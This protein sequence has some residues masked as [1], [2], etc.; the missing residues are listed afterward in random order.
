MWIARRSGTKPIDPGMLDNLVGGGVA[1]GTSVAATVV[2]EAWEEAGIPAALSAHARAAGSVG[3]LRMQPDGLHRETIHVHDLELPSAFAPVNQDGEV[4][5][6]RLV[7]VDTLVT[8]LG[9]AEGPDVMTA[10]AS[11]V[12]VDW[13]L[14]RGFVA[15]DDPAVTRLRALCRP[16][17]MRVAPR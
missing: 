3:I 17:P 8:V 11:L 15:R 14:R 6:Y 4:A 10:D 2:K 5:G 9:N 12:A 1:A 7:D 13:L 16:A